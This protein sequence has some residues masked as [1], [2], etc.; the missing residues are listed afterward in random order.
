MKNSNL[1]EGKIGVSLVHFAF[2]FLIASFLQA[3]YGAADLFVVGRYADS[4]AVS[5]V[6]I[7]SQVMQTITGII[8]GISMGGTVLIGR[9]V[10]E[11]IERNIRKAI[12]TL[13]ICFI[14][15]AFVLTPVMLLFT[16]NSVLFM[17]TPTEAI[18]D[19][20]RYIFI[21]AAGIPFIVGY[22]A[23]SGIYRGMGDS[24]TPVYFIALACLINLILDFILIGGLQIGAAG[25]AIATVFAQATSFI[26][27]LLYM[28]KQGFGFK[29]RWSDFKFDKLC[30]KYIFKVGVPLALQDALVNISFLIITAIINT[31]GLV[32]S[33]S[34]GVVE[35]TIVF[36]MLPQSAFASAVAAMS[37]QN[38]G[39][40]KNRRAFQVL[41]YGI[42]FSLVTGIAFCIYSQ[43]SPET[44]TAIFSKDEKVIKM[45]ALFLKSYS[46]DCILVS[47]VFCMNAY[48]SGC[49]K[50]I[51]SMIHSLI[52]TFL[53]RIPLSY[54]MSKIAGITLYQMGFAAPTA[55]LSSLIICTGYIIYQ[56]KKDCKK[57]CRILMN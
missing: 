38:I 16:K 5:S 2:P 27:A 17:H 42:S 7:G 50:S 44:I 57:D 28:M 23:V 14:L 25:A 46:I 26:V 18:H 47:F 6:A 39:A 56:R 19:T 20:T 29:M 37:A 10:G 53:I 31:M 3:F 36:A 12:G 51:V 35:K 21:C 4:A 34:V 48:F 13:T 8:L 15:L 43:F 49:G 30:A 54:G 33:A 11:K 41:L 55:T 52:A 9:S 40:G 22:N 1:T 32:A 24:K 45:A